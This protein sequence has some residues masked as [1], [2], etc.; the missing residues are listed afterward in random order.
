MTQYK[1]IP[2]GS[3][4]TNGKKGPGYPTTS[5][6]DHLLHN[7]LELLDVTKYQ[8]GKII[9]TEYDYYIYRWLKGVQ[10]PSSVYLAR[11]CQVI[12]MHDSGTP[13]N[14]I[15][16]IDW[17]LSEITWKDG[18]VTYSDHIFGGWGKVSTE[19]RKTGRAV[20]TLPYQPARPNGP[21]SGGITD[22]PG[23]DAVAP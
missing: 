21:H 8:L 12:I 15:S 11:L 1:Y 22:I 6:I 23:D 19:G 17:R 7:A 14:L 5:G 10:R 9:G 18:N 2:D 20:A 3:Y 16:R 13:V 4:V